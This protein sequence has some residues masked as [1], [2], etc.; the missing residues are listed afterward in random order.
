MPV[1]LMQAQEAGSGEAGT[2]PASGQM[3]GWT[4]SASLRS[5]RDGGSDS[6]PAGWSDDG[7]T[8]RGLPWQVIS[9]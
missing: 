5:C 1:N 7:E 4:Q 3:W 9:P 2:G 6:F 8:A